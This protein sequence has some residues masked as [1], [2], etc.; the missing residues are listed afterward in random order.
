MDNAE[1]CLMSLPADIPA[2]IIVPVPGGGVQFEWQLATRELEIEFCPGG[3]VEYLAVREDETADEGE[4]S[5]ANAMGI[6][7]LLG[8]LREW[9]L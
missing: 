2:P 7:A 5:A 6:Y 3:R 4:L 9:M 1:A 8:F